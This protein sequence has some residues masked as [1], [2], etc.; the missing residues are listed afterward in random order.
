MNG[1]WGTKGEGILD[2][3]SDSVG[4]VSSGGILA[5]YRC[6]VYGVWG[7]W[8]ILYSEWCM[9]YSVWCMVCNGVVHSVWFMMYGEL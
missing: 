8:C 7:V 2:C 4:L 3:G 9:A 1:V 6:M 5:P